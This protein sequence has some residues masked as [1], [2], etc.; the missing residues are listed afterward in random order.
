M[1]CVLLATALSILVACASPPPRHTLA[2]RRAIVNEM[3]ARADYGPEISNLLGVGEERCTEVSTTEFLCQWRV[4]NRHVGWEALST[5]LGTP[6]Q[7]NVM[8]VLP[9]DGAPRE[10]DSCVAFPRRSNRNLYV[11]P[12][13][14]TRSEARQ[15]E[16]TEAL[17]QTNAGEEL[18]FARNA[19]ELSW[20][21]G[22]APNHCGPVGPEERQCIWKAS[23]SSYGHGT[24]VAYARA[25]KRERMR[26]VCRLPLDGSPRAPGSCKVE[27]GS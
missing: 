17:Y 1:R 18:D 7:V 19:V 15:K 2:E 9:R 8:C 26:L 20:L 25:K 22:A 4:G 23:A 27:V 21:V 12:G 6:D 24:L 14:R 3:L 13:T 11:L 10:P 16:S 5:A